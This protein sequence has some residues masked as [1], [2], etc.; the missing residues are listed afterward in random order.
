MNIDWLQLI[1]SI[2]NTGLQEQQKWESQSAK[3]KRDPIQGG[4]WKSNGFKFVCA[5][6]TNTKLLKLNK[7]RLELVLRLPAKTDPLE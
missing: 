6:N 5:S 7:S 3:E 1:P 2:Q 4:C